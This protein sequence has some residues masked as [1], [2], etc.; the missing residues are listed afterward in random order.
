MTFLRNHYILIC[1]QHTDTFF[2][3]FISAE[4]IYAESVRLLFV[5]V[6]FWNNEVE[7]ANQSFKSSLS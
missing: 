7:K 1:K 3:T 2:G 6:W 5:D 4:C